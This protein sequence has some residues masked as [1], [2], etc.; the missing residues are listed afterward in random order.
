MIELTVRMELDGKSVEVGTL[1][2]NV[3]EADLKSW[4]EGLGVN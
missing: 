1:S 2:G 4:I 3:S